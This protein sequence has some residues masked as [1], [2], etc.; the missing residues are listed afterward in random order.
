M[1]KLIEMVREGETFVPSLIF[2]DFS[3]SLVGS[4]ELEKIITILDEGISTKDGL[5]PVE[6]IDLTNNHIC[7]LSETQYDDTKFID[8]LE[9]IHRNAKILR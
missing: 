4:E 5:S 9:A 2:L 1:E 7:H 3:S 8:L 6:V